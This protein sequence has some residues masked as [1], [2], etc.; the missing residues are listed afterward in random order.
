MVTSQLFG[1]GPSIGYSYFQLHGLDY[2]GFSAGFAPMPSLQTFSP[3]Y[4]PLPFPIS[5]IPGSDTLL[6]GQS[7]ST[8]TG[9][10]GVYAGFSFWGSF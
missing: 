3:A 10:Y 4:A 8:P 1:S 6:Y 9:K 7:L 5:S 2:H